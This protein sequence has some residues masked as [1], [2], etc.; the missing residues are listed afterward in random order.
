MNGERDFNSE[1]IFS[2]PLNHELKMIFARSLSLNKYTQGKY[3][4][5][6]IL[7]GYRER[8][9]FSLMPFKLCMD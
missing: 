3:Q 2:V 4:P 1:E 9:T 5:N 8:A 7:L 6:L